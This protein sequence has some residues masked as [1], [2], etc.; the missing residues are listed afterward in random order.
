MRRLLLVVGLCL[1]MFPLRAQQPGED[2]FDALGAK[3]EEYLATLAGE[4]VALQNA[5]CDYLISSCR[6]SLVRQFV[7]LKLY[8]HYLTSKIMGEE[9]V[10]VHVADEW[11]LSGKVKM[12]S[13]MDLLNAQ[14]F[15]EFNR[16]SLLGAPAPVL[17][18][19]DPDGKEVRVPGRDGYSLL[20]FYDTSCPTCSVET[21]RLRAY[22]KECTHPLTLYAV[23]TGDNAGEWEQYR[24]EKLDIDGAVHAWDPELDSDFQ[25][26]Y[27]VLQTP[28]MF[29]VGP[30]G[31]ILGRGLDT[32]GLR[33]LA[34]KVFGAEEYTYGTEAQMAF[35]E[36]IFAGYGDNLKASDVMDVASYV[37]A[38]T[39]GE[40]DIDSYKHLEGDL[41]Y[42]LSSRREEPYREGTAG[43]ID[44]FILVPD[45]WD[46][47]ADSLQVIAP[48]RMMKDL[49][50]RAPVGETVPSVTV[51][52]TLLRKRCLLGK[53]RREGR[54]AL[55]RLGG[56]TAYVVFYTQGC[57]QCKETLAA[58]DSLAAADRKTR[59]LLV[60]MDALF[61]DYPDE[62]TLL[63]DSFDLSVL[64]AVLQLDGKGTVLRRFLTL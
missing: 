15:A 40:G 9:G 3:L 46:T 58:A 2:R 16:P 22:L 21:V 7:T 25:R 60:D 36:N 61:A 56:K 45:I 4:S 17:Y 54:F 14:V 51:H 20:Y 64:P 31:L 43:F 30:D 38:R 26:Q 37:A 6:D 23:Y 28:R 1:A 35:Y 24:T 57:A 49:L 44:R 11:L 8:D 29:L 55:D 5:E 32:P 18:M 27:G 33:L 42:Y 39:Y 41:L 47:A 52:G 63:L 62:A 13:E 59:V 50:G 12:H 19:K 34:D 48:A 53:G 10:A